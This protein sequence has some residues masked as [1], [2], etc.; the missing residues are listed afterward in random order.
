MYKI[1]LRDLCINNEFSKVNI[2]LTKYSKHNIKF[3]QGLLQ[4]NNKRGNTHRV[5]ALS[6]I[7]KIQ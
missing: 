4:L 7:Y 6:F 5:G 3:K 1:Y 2:D